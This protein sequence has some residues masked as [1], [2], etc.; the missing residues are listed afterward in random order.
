[1]RLSRALSAL[2]ALAALAACE[3]KPANN[4]SNDKPKSADVPSAQAPSAAPTTAAQ[5]PAP[6]DIPAP[7]DVAAPPAD[8]QKTPSGLASKVLTP[9][10]G[11]DHPG[12][13]D[14][15]KVHYTGWTKDGKMF[16]SSIVRKEPATFGLNQV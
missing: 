10:T 14:R 15:V 8:A 12:P 13:E 3:S 6:G 9:G 11:K 5:A 16:D 4:D 1:M 7:P 2:V